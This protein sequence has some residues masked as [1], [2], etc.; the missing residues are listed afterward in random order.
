MV[1]GHQAILRCISGYFFNVDLSQVPYIGVPLHLLMKL[2]PD[3]YTFREEIVNICLETGQIASI[4]KP[5]RK[6]FSVDMDGSQGSDKK[7]GR[8][9]SV[10]SDSIF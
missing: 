2:T 3:N 8:F 1:I 5:L 9:K 6:K 10:K 7:K 4:E